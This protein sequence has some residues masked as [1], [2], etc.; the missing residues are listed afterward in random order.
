[1]DLWEFDPLYPRQFYLVWSIHMSLDKAITS[2][3]EKRKPYRKSKR[4]DTSCRNH[5]SC[6]WCEGNRLYQAR[7]AQE[8][9]EYEYHHYHT[10]ERE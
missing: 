1:L 4:F 8:Q 2:G 6:S 7:K 10:E 9:A 3:K 5:G